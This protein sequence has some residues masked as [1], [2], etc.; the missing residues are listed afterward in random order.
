MNEPIGAVC[1]V[2]E[3]GEDYYL[4]VSRKDDATAVG[5]PGGKVELG[6]AP[7]QAAVRE[8]AEETG[9]A[10]TQ[11]RQVFVGMCPPGSKDGRSFNTAAYIGKVSGYIH[12]TEAGHVEWVSR[13]TLLAGPFGDYNRRLFEAVDAGE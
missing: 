5:F 3:E 6:E 2:I 12:T 13:E 1:C 4:G 8:L 11:P 10:L 9:L 7:E